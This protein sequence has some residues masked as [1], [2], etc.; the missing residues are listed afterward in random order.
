M[1]LAATESK[2]PCIV[3][4]ESDPLARVAGLRTEIARLNA[5]LG[6]VVLQM[7]FLF[8]AFDN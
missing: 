8:L 2:C 1:A 7:Y 6:G 5:H 3:A 4:N